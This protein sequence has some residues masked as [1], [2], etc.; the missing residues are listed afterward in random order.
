M[1]RLQSP[2][3]PNDFSRAIKKASRGER[4]S[5]IGANG[6]PVAAIVSVEDAA[7]MQRLEDQ[8]DIEAAEKA[9]KEGKKGSGLNGTSISRN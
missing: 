2:K 9:L 8:Q 6:K 1:T 4:I 5:I 7:Y 3:S